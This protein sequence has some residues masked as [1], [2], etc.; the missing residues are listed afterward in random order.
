MR[1]TSQ[2]RVEA[3]MAQS[4]TRHGSIMTTTVRIPGQVRG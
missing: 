1:P 2:I 3:D 4:P